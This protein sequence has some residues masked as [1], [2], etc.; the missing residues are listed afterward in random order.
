MSRPVSFNRSRSIP[1]RAG[2]RAGRPTTASGRGVTRFWSASVEDTTRTMARTITSIL[3]DRRNFLL[4]R[5][6]DG[7]G[8]WS[9]E[10]PKPAGALVGTRGMR[11]AAMPPGLAE[12][13][14]SLL[15]EPIDFTH[16]DFAMAVHMEHHQRGASCF[17]ISYNR[18]KSWRGP[19]VLPLF[20]QKGVMGRTDY[21]A[22]GHHGCLLFLTATKADGTEGRPFSAQTADGGLSWQFL[23]FIGP[24]PRGYAVMPS[25]VRL[26][27]TDLIT[28]IRLRDFPRRWI[29]AYVSHDNGRSWSYLSTPAPDIGQG[30]P[31]S[32]VGLADGRL[33]LTYGYRGVPFAI[34]ARLSSDHGK[35]WSEPFILRGN[36]GSQ[37]IGYP[38]SVVRPDGKVVTVYGFHDRAGS[39]RDV[40]ATIWNPGSR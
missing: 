27:T 29:D 24:E 38:R 26:S 28:T 35:T 32:L 22:V 10:E 14:P 5:S 1:S 17:Y 25:T 19:F 4:A 15:R 18:G 37:D 11:H 13:R 36:G 16:P 39:V 20:G 3:T 21:I 9:I 12:E 33:C 40:E 6:K 2:S 34:H 31:P 30:N 8:S 23:S 7:G